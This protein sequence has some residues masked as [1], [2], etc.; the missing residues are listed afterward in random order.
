MKTLEH[1]VRATKCRRPLE[2]FGRP[3]R[4]GLLLP[5]LALGRGIFPNNTN[6]PFAP[7]FGR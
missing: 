2:L 7:G 3:D 6:S 4:S 5:S 1:P